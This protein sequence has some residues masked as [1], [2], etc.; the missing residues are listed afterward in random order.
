MK[1]YRLS[2]EEL[3]TV[4]SQLEFYKNALQIL[5]EDVIEHKN[6]RHAAFYEGQIADVKN[7]ISIV[8]KKLHE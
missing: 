8:E 2:L 1:D 6:T 7:A 5:L 3:I 4:R